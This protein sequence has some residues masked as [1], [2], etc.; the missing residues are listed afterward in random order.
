MTYNGATDLSDLEPL[1]AGYEESREAFSQAVN[2]L[3]G[4]SAAN[5]GKPSNHGREYWAFILVAK[6]AVTSMT[7]DKIA[8]KSVNP[9]SGELWDLSSVTTLARVLVE[10]YLMLVWLCVETEKQDTWDFRLTAL[11]IVDNRARY[12]LTQE[13]EGEEEPDDFKVAQSKLGARLSVTKCFRGHEPRKQ[14]E[15]LRG[16]K[17]PF[18]QDDV[19]GRLNMDQ[20]EFCRMYRYLSSFVHTNTISFFRM[21]DHNRG[22]GEFN[23]YEAATM[24]GVFLF[25]AHVIECAIEDVGHI[26]ESVT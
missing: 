14:R 8:P 10:N 2:N 4:L 13:V 22:K 15:L 17:M 18:I 19:I 5:E 7:L 16:N 21:A 25:A 23:T 12:R 24:S 26:I 11:T 9:D 20:P 6:L 3:V 1:A